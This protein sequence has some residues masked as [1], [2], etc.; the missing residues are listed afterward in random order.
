[1]FLGMISSLIGA[2]F[3]LDYGRKRVLMI[4]GGSTIFIFYSLRF[5]QSTIFLYGSHGNA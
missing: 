4:I 2:K 1:M 3:C 5:Y